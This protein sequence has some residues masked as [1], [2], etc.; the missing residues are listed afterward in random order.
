MAAVAP[1][2]SNLSRLFQDAPVVEAVRIPGHGR[3][4]LVA[5][6]GTVNEAE[7]AAHLRDILATAPSSTASRV[8]GVT[9]TRDEDGTRMSR[10]ACPTSP[11][12]W[13]WREI[14][15]AGDADDDAGDEWKQMAVLASI[16]GLAGIIGFILGNVPDMER[17]WAVFFHAIAIAAGGWD[18]AKDTWAGLRKRTLDIHFLMLAAAAGSA[19]L[20]AW[21]EATLLL[22]LFSGSGALEHFA[23]HRT[24]KEIQSLFRAAPR[25]A[26]VIEDDGSEHTVPVDAVTTGQV[27]LVRPG[28][29]FPVDGVVVSGSSA[30]D[31]STLTGEA[32]PIPKDA[33]DEVFS[34]TL[35]LWGVVRV[36]VSRPAGRSALQ[37]IITLIREAQQSKA[38]SQRFTDRFGTGYTWAVLGLT[39]AVFLFWWLVAGIPAFERGP[40]GYPA[41]YRAMTLLVVASPCALVLSI[42]SAILA[43]IAWGARHGILFRGGAAVEKLADIDTVCLDKT[44]TLTT[45]DLQ[46]TAVESYP[47]GRE[48]EVAGLAVTLE[49]NSTHPI[50]RAISAFGRK[51]GIEPGDVIGFENLT[52][53]GLR[54]ETSA[55]RVLLGKRG[56]LG[57]G[58][59]AARLRAIPWPDPGETE[60]WIVAENLLGR[61]LLRDRLRP[62]SRATLA[63]LAD[64]GIS[65]RMLTGDRPEAARAVAAELGLHPAHVL[66]G[67]HPEDK[68]AEIQRLTTSG[69]AV[70][71]VGDGINDAPSL[72]AAHVS[73][74]MGARGSDAALEQSEIVLMHDRIENFLA[75]HALSRAARRVIRQN[76]TIALGTVIVMV[77]AAL[78]GTIPL[79]L[80]VLA[81]EGST[82]IVCLNS[83]RLLFLPTPPPP[84]PT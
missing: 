81:H 23:L 75:A 37:K 9:I 43:A 41:V 18:A 51:H 61:I 6:L 20:G 52:G 3:S 34:G 69:H 48:Q 56:L 31:E 10:A 30:S 5:T 42:P 53:R 64:A 27:L 14:P 72:A 77:I 59:L 62:E 15:I 26:N 29:Q 7:L 49:K 33:G 19:A 28:D 24:R 12:L 11:R 58:E 76:I 73:V 25:S 82:V 16:C 79:S 55:G 66:A 45:G 13:V 21:G 39:L 71:M 68:V 78:T 35:N 57:E 47:P 22:F 46:V 84:M 83:L 70:A 40:H 80:G 67:L 50:A 32:N 60:V 4:I 2:W 54:A 36:R 8:P 63:R 1:D 38:P 65:T 74:A 44:G 17:G